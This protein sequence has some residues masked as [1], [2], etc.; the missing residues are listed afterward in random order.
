MTLNVDTLLSQWELYLLILV[1]ITAFIYT[2]TS[3]NV[4]KTAKIFGTNVRV[5]S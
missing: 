4:K 5:C 3:I 1:R 2:A